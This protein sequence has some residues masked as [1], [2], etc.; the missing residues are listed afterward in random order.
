MNMGKK[1]MGGGNENFQN[2][3]FCVYSSKA[4]I[5]FYRFAAVFIL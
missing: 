5:V 3:I 1:S 4:V 2:D